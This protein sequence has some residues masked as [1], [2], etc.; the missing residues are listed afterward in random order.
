MKS[1][2]PTVR[3]LQRNWYKSSNFRIFPFSEMAGSD[4]LGE[5][6]HY[7]GKSGKIAGNSLRSKE[8]SG[9]RFVGG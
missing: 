4:I 8:D 6:K 7:G 2:R 9:K 1:V 5:V 3:A